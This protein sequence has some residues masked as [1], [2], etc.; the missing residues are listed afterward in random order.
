MFHEI[1][2]APFPQTNEDMFRSPEVA[3]LPFVAGSTHAVT[4]PLRTP[5]LRALSAA[6]IAATTANRT[7]TASASS[8][9]DE[10]FIISILL[11][12][13]SRAPAHARIGCSEPGQEVGRIERLQTAA[14]PHGHSYS[15]GIDL[16][17]RRPAP[18]AAVSRLAEADDGLMH[19]PRRH[20]DWVK[21]S[22]RHPPADPT[23]S[24]GRAARAVERLCPDV[25]ERLG[26][27]AGSTR[28]TP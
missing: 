17:G 15:A 8:F 2:L 14:S 18:P 19:D 21:T 5:G 27:G 11:T 9:L 22:R 23:H 24:A 16:S 4:T 25:P 20:P 1:V 3:L 12:D 13:V 7:N 28:T 26:F 6:A 10:D